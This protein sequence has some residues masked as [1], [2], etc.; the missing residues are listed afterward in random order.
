MSTAFKNGEKFT[1]DEDNP[2]TNNTSLA[3][4]PPRRKRTL[5]FEDLDNPTLI[6]ETKEYIQC[7]ENEIKHDTP[8]P[9]K[10]WC[11]RRGISPAA[12]VDLFN[13]ANLPI[14]RIGGFEGV[15]EVHLWRVFKQESKRQIKQQIQNRVCA[16][17]LTERYHANKKKT[18]KKKKITSKQE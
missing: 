8:I 4:K 15:Y 1:I 5:Y 14:I 7:I 10:E 2:I 17:V 11:D 16:R 12:V 13:D 3:K 18:G 6:K 9:L